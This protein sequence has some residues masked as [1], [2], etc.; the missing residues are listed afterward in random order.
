MEREWEIGDT[1]YLKEPVK[2]YRHVEIVA[3]DGV[4]PV[5]RTTSGWEFSVYSDEL[6]DE[7]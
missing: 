6:T 4:R 1:A 2:G 7:Y 5:V 3:F